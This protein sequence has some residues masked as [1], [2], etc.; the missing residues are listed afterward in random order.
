MKGGTV[1]VK[2]NV[3][4]R[5]GD[6]MRRGIMLIEGNAGDYCGS[7][8]VAGTIA[9]MEFATLLK[10][11]CRKCCVILPCGLQFNQNFSPALF[12]HIAT[13]APHP[14]ECGC[15]IF[16]LLGINL[17]TTAI[18]NLVQTRI[19]TAYGEFVLHYFTN[20]LDNKEHAPP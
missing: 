12:S 3:G 4:Q 10:T 11:H 5:A 20:S 19:P 17:L 13:I 6:H 1:L 15:V 9:V 2:G 18:K 14:I 16:D 7:R 8:M